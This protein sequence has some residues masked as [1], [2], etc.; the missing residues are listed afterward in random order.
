MSSE[1][2]SLRAGMNVDFRPI[3]AVYFGYPDAALPLQR[4]LACVT[5]VKRART[6]PFTVDTEFDPVPG[7]ADEIRS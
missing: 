2:R 5:L 6:I 1:S 7:C 4:P 3:P